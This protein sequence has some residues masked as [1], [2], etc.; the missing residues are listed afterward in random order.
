MDINNV[1][2]T[3]LTDVST[4]SS[5]VNLNSVSNIAE[6]N[7]ENSQ[8]SSAINDT[9]IKRSSLSNS[10]KDY[11]N[12]ISIAQTTTVQIS[13]QE[14]ILNNISNLAST[15]PDMEDETT[16]SNQITTEITNYN[17]IAIDINRNL[18]DSNMDTE[19]RTYFDGKLGAKPLSAYE[20]MDEVQQKSEQLEAQ[21]KYTSEES[22]KIETR[23][24]DTIGK[25]IDKSAKQ[26]PFEPVDYGKDI[27][28]F[29]SANINTVLGSVAASQANAVPANSP[30]LLA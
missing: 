22:K 18:E 10:L 21:K 9:S 4:L 20:I 24:L 2:N 8:N 29:S 14:N 19:S 7:D 17:N 28:N 23:A 12:Q 30:K 15:I 5:S 1:T 6:L 13:N 27:G 26:A 25:E 16:L 3:S 11:M